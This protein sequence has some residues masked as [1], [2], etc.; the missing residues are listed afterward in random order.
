MDSD[1]EFSI[2]SEKRAGTLKLEEC[3]QRGSASKGKEDREDNDRDTMMA[4]NTADNTSLPRTNPPLI[5]R[6]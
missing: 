5:K 1:W 4:S 6:I 3:L 2:T